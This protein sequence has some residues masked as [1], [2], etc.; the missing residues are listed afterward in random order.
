[1]DLAA[2]WERRLVRWKGRFV[3]HGSLRVRGAM[4]QCYR[5]MVIHTRVVHQA[6][7]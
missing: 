1:M 5:E 4:N 6:T 2:Q 7:F 3:V